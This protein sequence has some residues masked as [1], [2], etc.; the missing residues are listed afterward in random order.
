M[1]RNSLLEM[2]GRVMHMAVRFTLNQSNDNPLMQELSL[3]GMNSDARK[4]VERIQS[5]GFTSTPL[6]RDEQEQ[7]KGAKQGG[8]SA[9]G[10]QPKGPAAEGICLFLGGQRNHP[11]C[12]GI[13]DRRHRPMGLKP[14]E[15]AQYDDIGQMTL[16][17]RAGLFMLSLDTKDKDGKT[18]ERF[19]SMRHVEKKKQERKKSGG[20]QQGQGGGAAPGTLAAGGTSGQS[21]QDFKH[22]GETVNTEVRC[23]AKRIEFRVGDEVVGYYDKAGKKW[24]FIGELHLGSEDAAHPVYGVNGGVG[25]T[26]EVSGNGAVLVNA[27]K[28]GPPTSLDTE[29]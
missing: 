16:L 2:S 15:N 10:E 28:P 9:A 14:G 26:T 13:D 19:V 7:K 1:N 6:P 8:D 18:T 29:P 27:P 4:V 23:S 20:T 5:F 11:V 17:R 25:K 3:D 21:Q 22:E 24:V 12:I